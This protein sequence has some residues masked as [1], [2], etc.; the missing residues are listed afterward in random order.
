MLIGHL[1]RQAIV[2]HGRNV[3]VLCTR[4]SAPGKYVVCVGGRVIGD[5]SGMRPISTRNIVQG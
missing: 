1:I 3:S 4:M 5:R 2:L